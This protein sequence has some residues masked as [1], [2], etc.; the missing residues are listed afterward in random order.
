MAHFLPLL[1]LLGFANTLSAQCDYFLALDNRHHG[2]WKSSGV[3]VFVND[4][5]V[6]IGLR[7]TDAEELVY[8][9]LRLAAD[10]VVSIA[11]VGS[12]IPNAY[13]PNGPYVYTLKFVDYRLYGP[14]GAVLLEATYRSTPQLDPSL[15]F[16]AA[17]CPACPV[18]F[19]FVPSALS[20]NSA[21][22]DYLPNAGCTD[23]H[24]ISVVRAGQLPET[25]LL[26]NVDCAAT[27]VPVNGLAP[28]EDYLL[29]ARAACG[30][31]DS[32]WAG[33]FAFSTP[34]DGTRAFP[35]TER[36]DGAANGWLACWGDRYSTGLY[37]P[38]LEPGKWAV[39]DRGYAHYSSSFIGGR[40]NWLIS[41]FVAIPP[42]TDAALRIDLTP[43]PDQPL[44]PEDRLYV[45][46]RVPGGDWQLLDSLVSADPL[47]PGGQ[48]LQFDLP[49]LATLAVALV[50]YESGDNNDNSLRLRLDDWTLGAW[51]DCP[52][53][54]RT[55][56]R[57]GTDHTGAGLRWT[58]PNGPAEW[59]ISARRATDGYAA[60]GLLSAPTADTSARIDLAPDTAYE[61]YVGASCAADGDYVGPVPLLTD[62]APLT[63]WSTGTG[64]AADYTCW[65]LLNAP[66]R[67]RTRLTDGPV[68]QGILTVPRDTALTG[69]DPFVVLPPMSN[70]AAGTHELRFR[71]RRLYPGQT[72][73]LR[74]FSFADPGAPQTYTT[75]LELPL[76]QPDWTDY[77][78]RFPDVPTGHRYL[79]LMS[80]VRKEFQ[81]TDVVWTAQPTCGAP[82]LLGDAAATDAASARLDWTGVENA[83]GYD[84]QLIDPQTAD[85]VL[86]TDVSLPFV[87]EDLL[88]N[89]SYAF[90]VRS[91]CAD[92]PSDWS[93]THLFTQDC[94]RY[95]APYAYDF[96]LDPAFA[97]NLNCW[98]KLRTGADGT[99]YANW[100]NW[101]FGAYYGESRQAR[102][103][104]NDPNTGWHYLLSP[105][106]LLSDGPQAVRFILRGTLSG[107]PATP[108]PDER[109]QVVG[110][111]VG[112]PD[113]TV[114]RSFG[115]ASG[116]TD[117]SELVE[118]T[119]PDWGAQAV[120]IGIRLSNDNL[121]TGSS[122]QV[123]L[124]D[125]VL[126]APSACAVPDAF[127]RSVAMDADGV[128][129]GWAGTGSY[130]LEVQGLADD[131][132]VI[133]TTTY[134]AVS[135][136]HLLP[137]LEAGA[138]YRYRLRSACGSAVSDWT[139][140]R[141][142]R[143]PCTAVYPTVMENFGTVQPDTELPACWE[144]RTAGDGAFV[145]VNNERAQL[146]LFDPTTDDRAWLFSPRLADT[147]AAFYRIRFDA[148]AHSDARLL[149]GLTTDGETLSAALDTLAPTATNT[150]YLVDLPADLA[151]GT[152]VVFGLLPALGVDRHATL[153]N[154]DI[155]AAESCPAPYLPRI[156]DVDSTSVLVSWSNLTDQTLAD[157]RLV[158]DTGDSLLFA[159][160]TPSSFLTDLSD[161]TT[162]ALFVRTNCGAEGRSDWVPGPGFTT[163][164]RA[165]VELAEAFDTNEFPNCWDRTG[166]AGGN[167]LVAADSQGVRLTSIGNAAYAG[168]PVLSSPYLTPLLTPHELRFAAQ[169][170]DSYTQPLE[171]IVEAGY[172]QANGLLAYTPL[173]EFTLDTD[174]STYTVEVADPTGLRRLRWRTS[175]ADEFRTAQLREVVFQPSRRCSAPNN[176]LIE[177]GAPDT[178]LDWASY[179]VDRWDVE[180][181]DL[182]A[183]DTSY[184]T[185]VAPPPFVLPDLSAFT[186]YTVRVRARCDTVSNWSAAFP[187]ATTC[188]AVIPD[189]YERFDGSDPLGCWREASGGSPASGPLV[190]TD[191]PWE[192]A[193]NL[194][195][196]SEASLRL[197]GTG[198]P[199]RDWILPP[200]VRLPADGN[201][202]LSA[203]I[204]LHRP[205]SNFLPTLPP[206][207]RLR[208]LRRRPG[209]PHYDVLR[210][211]D[212]TTPITLLGEIFWRVDLAA[213][214]GRTTQFALLLEVTEAHT[215]PFEVY[216]EH[217]R[218]RDV[219]G[220]PNMATPVIS[221][222]NDV[223]TPLTDTD[224]PAEWQLGRPPVGTPEMRVWPS[225][226]SGAA[227]LDLYLPEAGAVSI[228]VFDPS[229]RLVARHT[230]R[231]AAGAV[232]MDVPEGS[233]VPGVYLVRVR[234]PREVETLRLVRER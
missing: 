71:A 156:Y 50:I 88:A 105:E 175:V 17:A 77:T 140:Y 136:P 70:L 211:V 27:S 90:R 147:S 91:R 138:R 100:S 126:A 150:P 189:Y 83:T 21:T 153:D 32:P 1:F 87:A 131:N 97:N 60:P 179:P 85:T 16:T 47:L 123:Q 4:T 24:T 228:Q 121:T 118:L 67:A 103:A 79:G 56:G 22:F 112:M 204:R 57:T 177:A 162:Y 84:L 200:R 170:L 165:T 110:R 201:Y 190:F 48:T 102:I 40:H 23:G 225:P 14:D 52:R 18:P 93:P 203:N 154:I 149:V 129:L 122:S 117:T 63:D 141:A 28:G 181:V 173:A 169:Q 114:L 26:Q 216:V 82:I 174:Y 224:L 69:G 7:P 130:G 206:G 232:R 25:G 171:L 55:T 229:G 202:R 234:T 199:R 44:D 65:R 193:P 34:C 227:Y 116:I 152:R 219:D 8:V 223:L 207:T 144:A 54:G 125:F 142:F 72:N 12:Y 213:Y 182:A 11:A 89:Y 185:D 198:E 68:Y 5:A 96:A 108:G 10:D 191:S 230:E 29:Y 148:L 64:V 86:Y 6:Y 195:D 220:L 210:T 196:P 145:R 222:D 41:P 176:L 187:F 161:N 104:L 106:I 132:S 209:A 120:E 157:V 197:A 62:C 180:L 95:A 167:L 159:Q 31:T 73:T 212:H 98:R 133:N 20:G 158:A 109:L 74:L 78:V 155:R 2:T 99:F 194:T 38:Q 128:T 36:F 124:D 233:R 205:D 151:A 215:T 13:N 221:T 58:T 186:D 192:I 188:L 113:W 3:S 9:P 33:P 15:S 163:R 107:G 231:R 166:Q 139:G 164:C 53:P 39:S 101:S 217:F 127:S 30:D 218:V 168:Y 45:L 143:L 19:G 94:R 75:L 111:P 46:S 172:L 92:G 66:T 42:G 49:D 80:A 135:S 184:Y 35:Y 160:L 208:L 43:F 37:G 115:A 137:D 214:R 61:L 51:T 134:A 146:S 183:Q 178:R 81:V 119:L 76:E 59:R 226:T